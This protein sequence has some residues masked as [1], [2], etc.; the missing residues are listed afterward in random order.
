VIT[1]DE[2]D[3]AA[4]A[5]DIGVANVERDYLFGW[6]IAGLYQESGLGQTLV[7]KGGNALRK[8]YLP[9]ARFSEDL[10]FGSPEPID[11]DE[12]IA[13]LN[14]VCRLVE[15]RTG[16]AFELDRNRI[17][18]H[19]A[20]DSDRQ[21]YKV[22]LYFKDFAGQGPH[23]TLKI[24]VDVIE[25]DRL[26]LPVQTRGLIHQY[27]DAGDCAT[28][29]RVIK[30]EEALAD[31][32]K[33]LLQRRYCYDLFDAVYAIFVAQA[34]DVDRA[35][36]VRV[37]LKK[38][39]F[40]PSPGAAKNLLLG[41][42]FELF[43]GFWGKVVCPSPSRMTFD[44]AVAQLA[45][46]LEALFAPFGDGRQFEGAFFPAELRNP[47]LEAG[48]ERKLLELRYG[49]VTR[50]VEPYALTF[51]R[52]QD[53]LAREYFY[54]YDRTRGPSIKSFVAGKIES[55]TV[56]EEPFEPRYDIEL[57]KAGD[58]ESTGY[59]ARPHGSAQRPRSLS[60]YRLPSLSPRRRRPATGLGVTYKIACPYCGK[61]LNRS[62]F[63]T[64]LNAHKNQY[65]TP[66]PGRVGY[67][68]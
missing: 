48:S 18:D 65:G 6:L 34:L 35:E 47:I 39:I 30:L 44:D 60:S 1:L 36:I 28:D 50:V 66:C 63:S 14:D 15:A 32:L 41:L 53:G 13:Q 37:F 29:I 12:L 3:A 49:G 61:R 16:V 11:G 43:R 38:T 31:K 68:V 27:S 19:H 46:G 23:I 26:Y 22:R 67:P 25:H 8:G 62:Q 24:G 54:G 58:A 64:S 56:T 2:I 52:R 4:I 42:P 45:T 40:E 17:V 51:K 59:F 10:D 9:L 20:I 7:L 33:C 55:L 57:A 5:L 21:V